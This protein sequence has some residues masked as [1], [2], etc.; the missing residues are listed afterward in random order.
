[1]FCVCVSHLKLEVSSLAERQFERFSLLI[2]LQS[3]HLSVFQPE[4]MERSAD[5]HTAGCQLCSVQSDNTAQCTSSLFPEDGR[6]A[7]CIA[8][9]IGVCMC[10]VLF[11]MY[12]YL[13]IL[14]LSKYL[15][16]FFH[17]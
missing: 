2:T 1:M 5:G 9:R 6:L 3:L 11:P 16:G 15:C 4:L 12:G 8:E 17:C 14:C 7:Y 13:F 10:T